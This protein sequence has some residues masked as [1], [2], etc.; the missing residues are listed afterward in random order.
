LPE[1]EFS[2]GLSR[3]R[4][5]LVGSSP[6]PDVLRD[7]ARLVTRILKIFGISVAEGEEIG[8]G[9]TSVLDVPKPELLKVFADFRERIASAT[10][11]SQVPLPPH[12]PTSSPTSRTP[13]PPHILRVV[14][15]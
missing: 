6:H 2:A 7:S 8:Y 15:L 1:R 3:E 12:T 10:E 13:P 9:G 4:G 5:C 14:C 11:M